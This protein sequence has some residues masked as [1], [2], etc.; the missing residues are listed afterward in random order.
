MVLIPGMGH[1][2]TIPLNDL[3]DNNE[4]ESNGIHTPARSPGEVTSSLKN[5]FSTFSFQCC[6]LVRTMKA[7]SLENRPKN[8]KKRNLFGSFVFKAVPYIH[9]FLELLM[10]SL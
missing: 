6:S 2:E 10:G 3:R 5:I 1:D 8:R 9:F 4:N 7:I